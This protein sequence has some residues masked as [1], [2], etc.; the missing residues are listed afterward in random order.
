MISSSS[1]GVVAIPI[2]VSVSVSILV[3]VLAAGAALA[4]RGRRPSSTAVARQ[5]RV[6]GRAYSTMKARAAAPNVL[7]A[8][9]AAAVRA[10]RFLS[11]CSVRRVAAPR[12][13]VV[14]LGG[15]CARGGEREVPADLR[16][17][18]A[19]PAI[20][21]GGAQRQL[22]GGVLWAGL[23][24]AHYP[25]FL[26]GGVH[27]EPQAGGTD[28]GILLALGTGAELHHRHGGQFLAGHVG[29]PG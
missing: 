28:V 9:S 16:L 22:D 5:R 17:A 27:H 21:V 23:A 24:E 2:A 14:N 19:L 15:Q 25:R 3:L 13:L 6:F 10:V 11:M 18:F 26:P 8:R 7:A 1:P 12:A 20:D 4:G 29:P